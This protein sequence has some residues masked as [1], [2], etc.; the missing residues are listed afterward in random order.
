MIWWLK[1][2]RVHPFLTIGMVAYTAAALLV[3]DITILLPVFTLST[4]GLT[5]LAFFTPVIVIGTLAQVLDNRLIS[6]ETSG[7]RRIR[8]MDTAL[9]SA[10]ITTILLVTTVGAWITGSE[11]VLTT[12][13]NTCFLIGLMLCARALANRAGIILPL[14]WIFIVIF[15]GRKTSTSYY[16]WAITAQPAA[17]LF[18]AACAF[19]ALGLGLLLTY[20]SRDPL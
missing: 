20:H 19:V 8:L 10:T 7:V 12:G 4:S 16:E 9:I 5:Q 14:A 11:A 13:R 1:A 6:A 3:Q 15:F 17:S 2:R 18:P